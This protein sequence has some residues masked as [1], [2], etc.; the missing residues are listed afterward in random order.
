VKV[1][2]AVYA[3]VAYTGS[4]VRTQETEEATP[5]VVVRVPAPKLATLVAAV[6]EE[7]IGPEHC[8]TVPDEAAGTVQL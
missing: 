6:V 3:P 2:T 4:F 7:V 8:V 5:A 1:T